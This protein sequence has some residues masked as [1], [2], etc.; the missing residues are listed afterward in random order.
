MKKNLLLLVT[1]CA[2]SACFVQ[3][4]DFR[5]NEDMQF[6]GSVINDAPNWQWKIGPSQKQQLTS[7]DAKAGDGTKIKRNGEITFNYTEQN[8]KGSIPF[9]QGLMSSP[10]AQGGPNLSPVITITNARGNPLV[11]KGNGESQEFELDATGQLPG[12]GTT[13]G[14]VTLTVDSAKALI[15]KIDNQWV[16]ESYRGS[17]GDEALNFFTR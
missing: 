3:A 10:V 6:L 15:Y 13:L 5:L 8:S 7:F 14:V 9:I 16:S 11:L 2:S 4:K 1:I 17:I 12:G